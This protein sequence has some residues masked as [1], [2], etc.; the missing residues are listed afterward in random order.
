MASPSG[1][2]NGGIIGKSNQASFGKCTQT[3]RT[4]NT[5]SAVTTQSG[6]R[7]AQILLGAG[8][9]G[10][11]GNIGG[12]GGNGQISACTTGGA[13]AQAG[14]TNTGGG[15]GGAGCNPSCSGG[16]GAAGG[17]GIVIIRYKFQ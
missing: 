6:T 16:T 7:L 12:G 8:G 5:P 11:G 10:G 9:A 1:S 4:S 17:P 13:P 3:V 15:A 2:A 14:A